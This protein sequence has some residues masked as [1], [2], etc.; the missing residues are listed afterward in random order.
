MGGSGSLLPP[1]LCR[2]RRCAPLT[3]DVDKADLVR[4]VRASSGCQALP[5]HRSEGGRKPLLPLARAVW[6]P[7]GVQKEVPA[8]RASAVLL[9]QQAQ[10]GR[11]QRWLTLA[12]PLGPVLGQFRVMGRC[13]AH[14]RSMPDDFRPGELR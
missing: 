11:V 14:D 7:D 3:G 12:T 9:S 6:L 8:V 1:N 5:G 13:P 10:G 4:L 2:G